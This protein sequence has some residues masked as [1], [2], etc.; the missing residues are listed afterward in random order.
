MV[1][2]VA[3]TFC[4]AEAGSALPTPADGAVMSLGSA[5]LAW[6]LHLACD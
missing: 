5:Y 2:A 3:A 4:L 1:V 6:R